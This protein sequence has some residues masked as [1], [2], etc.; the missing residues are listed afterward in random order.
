MAESLPHRAPGPD[1]LGTIHPGNGPRTRQV[2]GPLPFPAQYQGVN[3]MTPLKYAPPRKRQFG[4][5]FVALAAEV[6]DQT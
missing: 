4:L 1:D 5:G 3:D 6:R 2:R